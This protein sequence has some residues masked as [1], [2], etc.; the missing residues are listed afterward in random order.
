[1]TER[2]ASKKVVLGE[3]PARLRWECVRI[4]RALVA[5]YAYS[6]DLAMFVANLEARV[7]HEIIEVRG[8]RVDELEVRVELKYLASVATPLVIPP[9]T[10]GDDLVAQRGVI[11]LVYASVTDEQPPVLVVDSQLAVAPS[12]WPDAALAAPSLDAITKRR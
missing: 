2:C 7:V 11:Q 10:I 4:R 5:A 3:F 9:L 1:M 12:R 6:T 8:N